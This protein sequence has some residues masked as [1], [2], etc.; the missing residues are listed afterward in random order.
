MEIFRQLGLDGEMEIESASDFDLDAG[1]LIVDKLI[2]GEVLAGMQEP[3]PARTAK[4]TPCKRLWLTQ[5]MFEP[6]L[7]RGA[8]RFGAEQ[9]FGTRVVHYE[10]QKDGVIVYLVACDGNRSATR[11]KEGIEWK[12]PVIFGNNLSINF[13][14]NLT[15]YLGS[16][17]VHGITY[18]NNK[19]VSAGF[20]LENGGKRG[21]M[22]VAKTGE[23]DDFEPGSNTDKEAWEVFYT[24]SGLDETFSLEIESV[25]YWTVAA[26]NSE[27]Y[28]SEKWP[29]IPC[30]RCGTRNAANGWNG[31][32][33][34]YQDAHNLA[35][36]LAYVINRKASPSLPKSNTIERQP[37]AEQ[38][39]QQAFARLANWVLRDPRINHD[40]DLPDDTCELGYRHP[41]G[42][43]VSEQVP[44]A[45]TVWEDPH[46]SSTR[47]K[48]ALLKRVVDNRNQNACFLI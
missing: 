2:G 35:W 38:I 28:S 33:Y 13:K 9:C 24:T 30:G 25:S 19:D 32:Q 23:K 41:E 47:Y 8:H 16:R 48:G 42:A 3:D 44:P 14:A 37:A 4:I 36:K 20:R 43:F 46:T 7:R 26:L 5:N 31:R 6:L 22:I 27:R 39:M 21:F 1:L 11:R 18:V 17:A 15:P 12:G 40:E 45:R 29:S 34:R 10:E